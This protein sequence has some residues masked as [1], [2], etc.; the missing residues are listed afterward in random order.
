[1][2]K[3]DK[4]LKWLCETFNLKL[5]EKLDEMGI[6]KN[7]KITVEVQLDRIIIKTNEENEND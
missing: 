5:S 7:E 1:M 2:E 6:Y 4:I 3:R